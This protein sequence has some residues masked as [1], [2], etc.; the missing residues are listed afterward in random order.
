MTQGQ[1]VASVSSM[2]YSNMVI[3]TL[4]LTTSAKGRLGDDFFRYSVTGTGDEGDKLDF[5]ADK[6]RERAHG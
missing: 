1:F 4:G 6:F 3:K 2:G 5:M